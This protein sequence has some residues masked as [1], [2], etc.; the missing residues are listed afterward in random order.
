M[1]K[2]DKKMDYNGGYWKELREYWKNSELRIY[3]DILNIRASK[4]LISL[5]DKGEYNDY[6]ESMYKYYK[7]LLA[8]NIEL[9]SRAKPKLYIYIVPLE[10]Y[11]KLLNIPKRYDKGQGGGKP[12]QCFDIDGYM[13]AYGV[14]GNLCKNFKINKIISREE[15]NIHELA[16]LIQLQFYSRNTF[17]SEGLA[18]AIPLYIM[19]YEN[20]FDEH[21]N[22][23]LNLTEEDVISPKDMINS[24]R[25]NTFGIT[26]AL[27]GKSC[28]FRYSYISSY[29]FVRGCIEIIESKDNCT[30]LAALQHF[31]NTLYFCEFSSE[32]LIYYIADYLD[33]DQDE[34]LHSKTIQL[35][36]I[37]SIKNNYYK[38][39]KNKS[40]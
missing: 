4:D 1:I 24:E 14:S 40:R 13:C 30:K 29:L 7:K 10:N 2:I 3:K 33:I 26:S 28:S 22:V 27:T 6:L 16:H 31:L 23:I 5:Y 20:I 11:S 34:L 32:F 36:A 8:L 38:S 18:E 21:R 25:N 39:S 12:V 9:P 17:I 35:N 37:E 15:N 19:E